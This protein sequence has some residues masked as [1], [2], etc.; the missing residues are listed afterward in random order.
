MLVK[1]TFPVTGDI[2]MPQHWPISWDRYRVTWTVKD[3]K[4]ES[5]TVA[6]RTT[7]LSGIPRIEQNPKPGFAAT[8][9]IGHQPYHEEVESIVRTASG[10]LGFFA[11]A[12]IAFDRPSIAWEGETA[13]ER[14]KLKMLSFNV[15]P[16]ERE[17]SLPIS[18][19]LVVRCF[20]SAL[21]ASE[22]EV[23]LSFMAKGR[24]DMLAERYID[25]YYS[26]YFFLETQFAPGYSDPKKVKAKFNAAPEITS[27]MQEARRMAA[28]EQGRVRQMAD[29]LKLSD[30][31]LVEHL[32]DT[33]GRLHHHALPRRKGS[34]HP[35]KHV[36]FQAEALFLSFLAAQSLNASAYPSYSMRRSTNRL[37]KRRGK[38][39]SR[40]HMWWRQ[41]EAEIPKA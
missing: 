15:G 7:D 1:Y 19:D 27:A 16:G 37:R 38:K 26:H 34:W 13:E 21:P 11:E 32:V 24:R 18:Y 8:I 14:E 10:I 3:G 33:R 6:V 29:L 5:V 2:F 36:E 23:P 25:A 39:A 35:D 41:K 40:T 20:L 28:S 4:A 12:D 30:P 22:K 17:E 9:H 31:K